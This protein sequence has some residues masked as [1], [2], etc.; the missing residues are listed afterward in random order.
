MIPIA[1]PVMAP[2]AE[3]DAW[4][5][6]LVVLNYV[7]GHLA[8]GSVVFPGASVSLERVLNWQS[9]LVGDFHAGNPR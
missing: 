3:K 6:I 8:T 9:G 4:G 2:E 7:A 5:C 1:V